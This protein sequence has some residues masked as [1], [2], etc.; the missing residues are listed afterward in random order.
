MFKKHYDRMRPGATPERVLAIAR[1]IA[2][3]PLKTIEVAKLC[4]LKDDVSAPSEGVRYSIN[5]AE[6]LGLIKGQGEKY[7]F[8]ANPEVISSPVRFRRYAAHR[9]LTNTETTF[10][11]VTEWFVSANADVLPINTFATYAAEAVKSGI[12]H[13]DENDILGWRFWARFLG[14]AYQ[15]GT[16]LI[17][18][19]CVRLQDAMQPF[20]AEQEIGSMEFLNWLKKNV[21]EAASSCSQTELCLAVSNGLRT[22]NDLG[23][24]DIISANDAEKVHMYPLD[25]VRLNDFSSI[26]VK[27]AMHNELD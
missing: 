27:E 9:L 11:K 13:V 21:P 20:Q 24:I 6:E 19:L 14:C 10:F 17:P 8:I 15:Y 7:E 12:D 22:L 1:M 3:K 16:T 5:T 25:G 23:K 2:D 18:N 26:L 4:E